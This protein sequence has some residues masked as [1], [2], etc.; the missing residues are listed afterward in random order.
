MKGSNLDLHSGQW[1]FLPRWVSLLWRNCDDL[2]LNTAAHDPHGNVLDLVL[3]IVSI[4]RHQY[5]KKYLLATRVYLQ[6][7]VQKSPMTPVALPC[8]IK[9]LLTSLM[10]EI[11]ERDLL[12]AVLPFEMVQS[13]IS[14]KGPSALCTFAFLKQ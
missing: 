13:P 5:E 2:S 4:I 12:H 9:S 10:K 8:P 1:C 3:S 14:P 6:H 7:T 11:D